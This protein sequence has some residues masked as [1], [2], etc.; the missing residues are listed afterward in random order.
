MKIRHRRFDFESFFLTDV[1]K[2]REIK[3]WQDHQREN[4]TSTM[5]QAEVSN[6]FLFFFGD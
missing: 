4:A 2:E 1:K 5:N 6:F 3:F